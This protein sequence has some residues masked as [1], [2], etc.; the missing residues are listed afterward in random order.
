MNMQ[1]LLRIIFRNKTYSFLNIAGLAIGIS[2][3]ALI[4]LWVESKVNYNKAIPGSE[5]IYIVGRHYE[6]NAGEVFTRL[7]SGNTLA[8]VLEDEFPE[9]KRCSRYSSASLAFVEE[10]TIN[11]FKEDGAYTD[12]TL[13]EMLRMTFIQGD[14]SSVFNNHNAIVISRSM[15]TKIY[16][17][18]NPVGKGLLNE[19]QL[20]QVAG[21]FKDMPENTT[22]KFEWLIPFRVLEQKVA[23]HFSINSWGTT[24]LELYVE[25]VAG[26]DIAQLNGKLKGVAGRKGGREYEKTHLFLYP[27]NRIL[28]YGEFKNGIETGGG[29]I[30]TVRLFFLVGMLIL[31]IACI[32]FMNLSTARSQ[33]RALEVGVSKTFGTK[34]KH[35]IRKFL[36]ES[37]LI[38]AIA[39]LLSMGL[40]RLCLPLFNGLIDTRLSFDLANPYITGGLV[41]IGLFCTL[42]AGSY[43]AFYLSSFNPVT[44]LKMQRPGKGGSASWIRRG[45]VVFQFA[46]AFILICTTYVIYLQVLGW[47][48]FAAVALLIMLIAALTV[49]SISFRA[50]I[51]N[52]VKS[53]KTE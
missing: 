47:D 49:S 23:P 3:A 12:S 14:I 31:L 44:T 11:S 35:L 15:A 41:A 25:P 18:E 5:N 52:P 8:E 28:L 24:W 37:G 34:R 33:K 36:A 40:V 46:M 19:G 50:A 53:I 10:N 45:L 30:R 1:K 22:F 48:I 9:V 16:G 20:Y 21:V 51:S 32:N 17:A 13:F 2:S 4:F 7:S 43:P 26:A 27:L 29:Y 38:T 39:L 42:L 6:N